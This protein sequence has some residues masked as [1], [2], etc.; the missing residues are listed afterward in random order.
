MHGE[1]HAV[2][3]DCSHKY[4]RE[5]FSLRRSEYLIQPIVHR[6]VEKLEAMDDNE[7]SRPLTCGKA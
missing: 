4:H 6:G 3:E 1:L 7:R 5:R 2:R